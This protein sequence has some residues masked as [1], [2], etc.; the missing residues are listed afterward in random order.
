MPTPP[1]PEPFCPTH[2]PADPDGG[3]LD[4]AIDIAL[5]R[6]PSNVSLV[7]LGTWIAPRHWDGYLS[8]AAGVDDE[9]INEAGQGT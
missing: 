8:R 3:C 9:V 4:C 1:A 6:A 7:G 2:P 5:S